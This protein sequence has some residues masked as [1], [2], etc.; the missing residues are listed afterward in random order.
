MYS[1][2]I[3]DDLSALGHFTNPANQFNFDQ[4][5]EIS[6]YILNAETPFQDILSN[7]AVNI[8]NNQ[9][10]QLSTN[11]NNETI[12]T[13]EQQN[14]ILEQGPN[15]LNDNN[16]D[17]GVSDVDSGH[18]SSGEDFEDNLSSFQPS[19]AS[20]SPAQLGELDDAQDWILR[21][22]I[23]IEQTEIPVVTAPLPDNFDA[24]F[25][26]DESSNIFRDLDD[27][28]GAPNAAGT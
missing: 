17:S 24:L 6:A 10:Q 28:I 7:S 4:P 12:A 21:S 22:E 18:Q 1:N 23:K 8:N 16:D 5:Q 26:T 19:E 3:L 15:V 2:K 13:G 20:A 14:N 9:S 27:I 11:H 25:D